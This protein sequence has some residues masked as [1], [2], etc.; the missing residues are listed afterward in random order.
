MKA[1]WLNPRDMS[2]DVAEINW[3]TW[4][5]ST[6]QSKIHVCATSVPYGARH[7]NLQN[8]GLAP[9]NNLQGEHTQHQA[10]FKIMHLSSSPLV[11]LALKSFICKESD[12]TTARWIFQVK[13]K[14]ILPAALTVHRRVVPS[15]ISWT[16]LACFSLFDGHLI[17][18]R[19]CCAAWTVTG[20]CTAGA[21]WWIFFL[22]STW[23]VHHGV[24]CHLLM[25]DC[26]CVG[27]VLV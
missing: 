1:T 12:N 15:A 4:D 17:L 3:W 25:F 11:T 2:G 19:S 6:V 22:V 24:F 27:F 18:W 13:T 9:Q 20:W 23:S 7:W 26:A 5:Q 14:E 10:T 16:F 21:A 8:L